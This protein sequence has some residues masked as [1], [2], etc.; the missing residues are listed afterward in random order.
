MNPRQSSSIRIVRTSFSHSGRV[1]SSSSLT[2]STRFCG[3][4]LPTCETNLQNWQAAPLPRLWRHSGERTVL[5][6]ISPSSQSCLTQRDKICLLINMF[7]LV[8]LIPFRPSYTRT[9]QSRFDREM[10][11]SGHF[12]HRAYS[13][14][15]KMFH[16]FKPLQ[17]KEHAQ[18]NT[19][20]ET[21][22]ISKAQYPVRKLFPSQLPKA[23]LGNRYGELMIDG[24][25]IA[26]LDII[27]QTLKRDLFVSH[28]SSSPLC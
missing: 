5:D 21:I 6:F 28:F 13:S 26:L 4:F 12:W 25:T 1:S 10:E 17:F 22:P 16:L 7:R 8:V 19:L 18:Y 23:Y 3:W 20:R 2:V 24:Y 14:F 9:H 15:V 27:Q 11:G